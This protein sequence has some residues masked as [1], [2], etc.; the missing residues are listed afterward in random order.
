[1]LSAGVDVIDAH[2]RTLVRQLADG[3]R[4]GGFSV[5]G[6]VRPE[7]RSAIVAFSRSGVDHSELSRRL[8]E[9]R[10]HHHVIHE[11]IRLSPQFFNN[12]NDVEAV[13][14]ALAVT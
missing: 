11:R 5:A 13:F 2:V 14:A 3:L 10:I 6:S 4:A 7:E 8:T 1:M 12:Q 9:R